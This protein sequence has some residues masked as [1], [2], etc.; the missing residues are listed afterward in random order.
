MVEL[1]TVA[2][3]A[4]TP[5]VLWLGRP[6]SVYRYVTDRAQAVPVTVVFSDHNFWGG[7]LG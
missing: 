2:T 6:G 7:A 4:T 3:T 5:Q 1:R